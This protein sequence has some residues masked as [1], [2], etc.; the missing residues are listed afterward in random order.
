M[1][2]LFLVI[3]VLYSVCTDQDVGNFRLWASIT[4]PEYWI[5][6]LPDRSS[7]IHSVMWRG[8]GARPVS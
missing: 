5:P 4:S 1:K 6:T 7:W 8:V 3:S 2:F